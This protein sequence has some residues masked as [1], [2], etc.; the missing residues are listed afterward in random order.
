MA[1]VQVSI[2]SDV[3]IQETGGPDQILEIWTVVGT[4][5][6]GAPS[7]RKWLRVVRRRMRFE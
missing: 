7:R 2:S 4:V 5:L 1:S 6:D 3:Q